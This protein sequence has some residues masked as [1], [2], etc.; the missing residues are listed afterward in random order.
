MVTIRSGT[1]PNGESILLKAATSGYFTGHIATALSPANGQ[2][3]IAHGDLIDASFFDPIKQTTFTAS[4]VADLV[5]PVISQ[6]ASS[7]HLARVIVS[8][9]TDE[10]ANSIV[11]FGLDSSLDLAKT[12]SFFEESHEMQLDDLHPGATYH[13][14]VISRDVA[15]NFSTN[16]NGGQ[17]FTVVAPVPP[18][19]L[20]V[21]AFVDDGG[22]IDIPLSSYTDALDQ[23]GIPYQLWDIQNGEPSPTAGDLRPYRVVIWRVSDSPFTYP[24][25]ITDAEQA[26][27][28]EY[29]A[30]G[31]AFLF[32]SMEHL[33]RLG[34]SFKHDILHVESFAEDAGVPAILG[35]NGNGVSSGIDMELNYE[36]YDVFGGFP[37]GDLSDTFTLTSDAAPLFVS[38]DSHE[39][40]GMTYPR[41]G[42]SSTGRVV[43]VSFPLDTVP[44]TGD[45]PNNRATMLKNII[46]FLAPG[47]SGIGTINFDRPRYTLPSLATMEVADSD[48]AGA[49][50]IVVQVYS[51]LRT[52]RLSVV[53]KETL[54]P[55]VFRGSFVVVTNN[56]PPATNQ[57]LWARSGDS[58]HAEYVDESQFST[59]K[60]V[61][62]IDTNAP[63]IQ[64]IQ[65]D[66][67]YVDFTISWDTSEETDALVEFGE[68]K[69][70]GRTA[71]TSDIDT[72]HEVLVTGLA[73]D[74]TY[75]YRL[76]SRDVAGNTVIKDDNG[77][78]YMLRTLRPEMPPY[79]NNFDGGVSGW[80]TF[81][82]DESATK[83]TLGVPNNFLERE[84]HSPPYAWGSCLNGANTDTIDTFLISPAI[85]LTQAASAKVN[86]WH[87]YDFSQRTDF[88]ILEVGQLLII[89]NAYGSETMITEFEDVSGGWY[90]E[91]IDLTPYVGN[92]VYL[93]W[94]HLLFSFESAPRGGWFLDDV[95][96]TQVPR[97]PELRI[98]REGTNVV[99][100]W[101]SNAEGYYLVTK[102]GLAPTTQWSSVTNIPVLAD[103][104]YWVT[105]APTGAARFYQL[106][107][108]GGAS[109]L[110]ISAS[111]SNITLSW[112]VTPSEY[113]LQSS[114]TLIPPDWRSVTT[115]PNNN[116]NQQSLTLPKT[117]STQFFRLIPK[118]P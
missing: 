18:P 35:V 77:Q 1:E 72:V 37:P 63:V 81:S 11:R 93:V 42:Q 31:G 2:L 29:L 38:A 66:P 30:G 109:P 22:F 114:A 87:S 107:K 108:N 17:L 100:S 102:S 68:S 106:A 49:T 12:N 62:I 76:V 94:Y 50:Q 43:F 113:V 73:P 80:D 71:H 111:G 36:A 27:I 112:P 34:T 52:N 16:D 86:F 39:V 44:E 33:S 48:L 110:A 53:L 69:F 26:A 88:D 64:N 75:Y 5:P 92:V 74:R 58:I 97:A 98:D 70:L 60:A 79:T 24:G 90:E 3:Q 41:I 91:E 105:N 28:R 85:D 95:L 116:G 20:L 10:P 56:A 19:V 47:R 25:T 67:S 32:C 82:S 46:D 101:R 83:W 51:D 59:V 78:P 15:G 55:G 8:W 57:Q 84:A 99:V 6:V 117:G 14:V 7:E 115:Q 21:N 45:A 103:D 23:A 13:Y 40:V 104:R 61:A 4:A 54:P 89:T 118:S 96:F 65:V 9:E